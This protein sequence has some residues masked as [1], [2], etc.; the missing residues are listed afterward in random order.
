MRRFP[1]RTR[2]LPPDWAAWVL[3]VVRF[4]CILRREE[5][6]SMGLTI[7]RRAG[8]S[9]ITDA[10][11]RKCR[12]STPA[13]PPR[14]EHVSDDPETCSF[15][16][17]VNLCVSPDGRE[18]GLGKV[19]AQIKVLNDRDRGL[20]AAGLQQTVR[21]IEADALVDTGAE[22]LALPEDLI[23]KLGLP[24]EGEITVVYANGNE[25]L[26]PTFGS[27][28]VEIAGRRCPILVVSLPKGCKVLVGH[29]VLELLDLIVDSPRRKLVPNTPRHRRTML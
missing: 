27:A 8:R 24:A 16:P 20:V 21:E 14:Q 29:V 13:R 1:I 19:N 7:E 23:G 3:F 26:R 11:N 28:V 9:R 25:E 10:P 6:R 22:M 17:G 5:G 18:V 4:S 12:H 2:R 15:P